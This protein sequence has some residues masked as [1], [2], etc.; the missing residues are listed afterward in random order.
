MSV[1]FLGVAIPG[2]SHVTIS[3][4][5]TTSSG[6]IVTIDVYCT[7]EDV[8]SYADSLPGPSLK[9]DLNPIGR[10][11]VASHDAQRNPM[12]GSWPEAGYRSRILSGRRG[13]KLVRLTFR[14]LESQARAP[15][16]KR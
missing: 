3:V 4:G 8:E 10:L 7:P 15:R 12:R 1:R 13:A 5:R 14:A 16:A 6:T 11:E 9:V 2:V